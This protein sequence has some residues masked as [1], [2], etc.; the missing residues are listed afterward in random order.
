M[1]EED[2]GRAKSPAKWC[3]EARF[4]AAEHEEFFED[5]FAG[6]DLLFFALLGLGL[7][8]LACARFGHDE[9]AVALTLEFAVCI[10]EAVA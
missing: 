8:V 10:F 2:E 7:E 6:G 1:T 3:L 4:V 9:V 5:L